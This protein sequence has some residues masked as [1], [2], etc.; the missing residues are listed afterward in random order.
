MSRTA[1]ELCIKVFILAL[2]LVFLWTLFGVFRQI[3]WL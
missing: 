1:I 3:G 2:S